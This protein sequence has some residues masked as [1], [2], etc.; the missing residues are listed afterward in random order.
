MPSGAPLPVF[1]TP[2]QALRAPPFFTTVSMDGVAE[3]AAPGS[4][5][6]VPQPANPNGGLGRGALSLPSAL[7][8][9]GTWLLLW[10]GMAICRERDLTLTERAPLRAL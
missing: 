6:A 3:G 9:M 5:G 4:P 2:P 8:T 1:P 10:P 7:P